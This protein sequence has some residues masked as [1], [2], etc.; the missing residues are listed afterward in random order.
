MKT[1]FDTRP[2]GLI[3]CLSVSFPVSAGV[4]IED[5]TFNNS[6]RPLLP[7]DGTAAPVS[8]TRIISGSAIL[9]LTDV[10]VRFALTNPQPGGAFNGDY[11]VSLQHADGFSVLLNRVGRSASLN[12]LHP[13]VGETFGYADNGF[14]VILDDSATNGDIH[15]YRATLATGG[16]VDTNYRLPLTGTWAPDGRATSP[17]SV[18]STDSRTALLNVFNGRE[19]NGSWTLQVMD[20][21]GG[22]SASLS[23]W[24]L[25][26][27]GQTTAVPEPS[28]TVLLTALIMAVVASLRM[29]HAE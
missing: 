21:N 12:P 29:R 1:S 22:G 11:Y 19:A 2:F 17:L 28:A 26:F 3:A 20:F 15:T 7:A 27:S 24:G 23:S 6:A 9:S 18:R 4:V 10:N 25:S 8:D 5:Y 13:T 16:P 14:D